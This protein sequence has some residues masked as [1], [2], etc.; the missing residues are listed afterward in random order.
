MTVALNDLPPRKQCRTA[1][2]GFVVGG[3]DLYW[4]QLPGL[5]RRPH[6]EDGDPGEWVDAWSATGVGH[7]W[8]LSVGHR[9]G[10]YRAAADLL[11][12]PF[13]SV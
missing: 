7:H 8:S 10:D 5:L 12:I 2:I 9:A 11:G 4:P 6:R 13:R 1:R 3:L